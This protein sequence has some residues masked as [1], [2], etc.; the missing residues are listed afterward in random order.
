MIIEPIR[1]LY[2]SDNDKVKANK[3]RVSKIKEVIS[4]T[5]RVD[6]LFII[7]QE[8]LL[9]MDVVRLS[10]TLSNDLFFEEVYASF[11]LKLLDGF[12]SSNDKISFIENLKVSYI[13]KGV[14]GIR[15]AWT[16]IIDR[17][18]G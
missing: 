18:I 9:K 5:N 12:N 6:E 8:A 15:F 13:L 4:D 3:L 16:P 7:V 2:S 14:K 1:S 10:N 17:L 11:I